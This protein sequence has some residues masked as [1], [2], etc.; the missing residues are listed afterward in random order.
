MADDCVNQL[1]SILLNSSI[2]YSP[3]FDATGKIDSSLLGNNKVF[4]G[5]FDECQALN[6]SLYCLVDFSANFTPPLQKPFSSSGLFWGLCAV[7]SCNETA[8]EHYAS[9][10]I[11]GVWSIN[12]VKIF[13][14]TVTCSKQLQFIPGFYCTLS[15]L[16]LLFVICLFGTAFDLWYRFTARMRWKLIYS[17]NPNGPQMVSPPPS[18]SELHQRDHTA[19]A[20]TVR[21][22]DD[23]SSCSTDGDGAHDEHRT[24]LGGSWDPPDR[25]LLRRAYC[26]Q[27][28]F[29]V[30][31]GSCFSFY[32]NIR[33]MSEIDPND[34]VCLH[35]LRVIGLALIIL[36]QTFLAAY[37][38]RTARNPNE[39]EKFGRR[40]SFQ[41]IACCFYAVDT[42]LL[43]SGLLLS[44]NIRQSKT[45]FQL[46]LY[47]IRR[48]FRLMPSVCVLILIWTFVRPYCATGPIWFETQ[49]DVGQCQR[50]W[51][52]NLLLIQNFYPESIK[53]SCIG[54]LW[55][56]AVDWQL[57]CIACILLFLL[58]RGRRMLFWS[59]TLLLIVCSIAVQ[60]VLVVTYEV[61]ANPAAALLHS[62]S[63][64]FWKY[65]NVILSK[66]YCRA[67]PFLAGLLLGQKLNSERD[68]LISMNKK[69]VF[70]GWI[71][72]LV[73]GLSSIYSLYPLMFGYNYS[74][75]ASA[76]CQSLVSVAWTLATAWC[77]YASRH[78][79]AGPLNCLFSW[80]GWVVLSRLSF[81]AYLF[82]GVVLQSFF[83]SLHQSFLLSDVSVMSVYLMALSLS[84]VASVPLYLCVQCPVH[85]MLS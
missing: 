12:W 61:G 36:G 15:L 60:M 43:M 74:P 32:S 51:W 45:A 83:Q 11:E 26:F 49:N 44:Y 62:D 82:H 40:F 65:M 84:F 71:V 75:V 66:P 34:I 31:I 54:W 52:T 20:G 30:K 39:F 7:E 5:D 53:S 50:F 9:E 41:P 8:I 25:T 58:S 13:N 28:D 85:R 68:T 37:A 24:E 23:P 48:Y 64:A 47:L 3:N 6:D 57:C 18:P 38:S 73:L 27:P 35:A 59:L 69:Y 80:K 63:T 2:D 42:F 55:Y 56:L 81:G 72:C 77:I 1:Q 33:V 10:L 16:L 70:C 78:L 67:V 29:K 22:S 17:I 14:A 21:R 79:L 76:I 46:V 4:F 19:T